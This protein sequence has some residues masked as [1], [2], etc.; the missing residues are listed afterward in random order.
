MMQKYLFILVA[1]QFSSCRS[2]LVRSR[3]RR[4]ANGS[5]PDRSAGEIRAI[6]LPPFAR[7]GAKFDSS[8]EVHPLRDPAVEGLLKQ[9]HELE[10]QHSPHRRSMP[11]ARR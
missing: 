7:A 2:A 4:P 8:V 1:Q 5:K 11:C 10:A 6:R 9:A 3:E